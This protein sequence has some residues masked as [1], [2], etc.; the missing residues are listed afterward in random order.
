MLSKTPYGYKVAFRIKNDVDVMIEMLPEEETLDTWT[1][2][3]TVQVMR[4]VNGYT[5]D[6]FYAGMKEG[7]MEMCSRG[8]VQI[9]ERGHEGLQPTLIWSQICAL[10]RETGQPEN[11]WFKLSIPNGVLVLVQKTFRFTPTDDDIATWL[12]FLRDVRVDH[13]LQ[14]LH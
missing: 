4:N 9:I 11:T 12:D 8:S 2:M 3:L 6:S 7:W 10:N 14:A 5:L 13:R 1:E